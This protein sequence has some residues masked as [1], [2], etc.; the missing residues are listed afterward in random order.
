MK[1]H[2]PATLRYL[3]L[4]ALIATGTAWAGGIDRSTQGLGPLFETGN[5]LE[6]SYSH[7]SPHVKGTDIAG[8]S[9]GDTVGKHDLASLSAKF[10]LNDTLSLGVVLDQ[11]YG[12]K[13]HYQPSSLLLG[14]TQVSETSHA[15]LGLLR[16]R[17]D[18]AFS[19]HGGL[20]VQESTATI[21]LRGLAYGPIKGYRVRF[22][23]DT[24]ASWVA[25]AAYEIPAIALRIAGTYHAATHHKL[26]TTETGPAIDPDRSGPLPA[27]PLLDGQS[28]T[29]INTP[30]SFN[31]D[32]QTGIA[33]DTLLFGQVRWVHWSEFRV[34]PAR[35]IA[36]TGGGLIDLKDTRS[37][38]LG[39]ARRFDTRWTGLMA[40]NYESKRD[41]FN[42]PLSPVNGRR[43]LSL[44]AIFTEGKLKVT[45]G[46]TYMKLGDALLET[47]T[48]DTLRAKMSGNSLLGVGMKVGWAL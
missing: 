6:M 9:T 34:D 14:G 48:P 47:G 31:L 46:V 23:A 35:F 10:D 8:G 17:L 43:G 2:A 3:I 4:T 20:R 33:P 15:V 32:A 5:Y 40:L 24:R 7:V 37:F 41:G 38:T 18:P 22:D 29:R 36:V 28:T 25:G 44:G 42:S 45:A 12:A 1:N 39:L 26:S 19:V 13:L 27:L 11:P 16:Y 21:D 30:A